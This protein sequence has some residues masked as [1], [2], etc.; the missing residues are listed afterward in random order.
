ME[1]SV[2]TRSLYKNYGSSSA[3]KNI[4]LSVPKGRVYVLLGPNGAGKS[5]TLSLLLGLIKPTSG[6]I[7]LFGQAWER[8]L[9]RRVGASINGPALYDHLNAY[10]NLEVHA[11][12]LDLKPE[13]IRQAL[14]SV[15]LTNTGNKPVKRFSMGMKSRLALAVALLASPELLILDEPQNGLDP[16]GIRELRDLLKAY[17]KEGNTVLVSSHQLG[18]VAR[19][20]DYIGIISNGELLYQGTLE[21]FSLNENLLEQKYLELTQR[22]S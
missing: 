12:M 7:D 1:Y 17:T 21:E 15:N 13:N 8:N 14:M 11:K 16:E 19:L 3:I 4:N 2:V 22:L 9:L 6:E 18:E 10:E 20:A 5:T